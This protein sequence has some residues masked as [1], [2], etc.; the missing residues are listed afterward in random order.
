MLKNIVLGT[1]GLMASFAISLSAQAGVIADTINQNVFVDWFGSHQYTHD[2]NDDGFV[3]GTAISG[4][5]EIA[6]S[7]DANFCDDCL[8]RESI[9]VIVDLLDGDTGQTGLSAADWDADLEIIALAKVN[10]DGKLDV[11]VKSIWGDFY[12]GKSVLTVITEDAKV[13]AP[14]AFGLIGIGLL[15]AGFAGRRRRAA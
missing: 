2:L 15:G 14:A 13:P 6:I 4:T 7:D 5:L 3:L 1:V 8:G 11:E 10:A 12:V 9:T